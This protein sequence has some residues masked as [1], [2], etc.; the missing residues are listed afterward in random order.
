MFL[1]APVLTYDVNT[2]PFPLLASAE[3][4]NLNKA[5]FTA[6]ATNG[7][8]GDVVLEGIV[9]QLPVGSDASTLTLDP[10]VI[11]PVAPLGWTLASIQTPP[12]LVQF[13]FQPQAG[14]SVLPK[15]Q[16]LPFVFNNIEVNRTPGTF[17]VAITEGTG[18][19]VP[20]DCPVYTTH[21]TKFP[22]WLGAGIVLGESGEHSVSGQHHAV[23][24]WS[25]GRHLHHPIHGQWTSGERPRSGRSAAGK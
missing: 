10:S 18:N 9:V 21:I 25:A 1:T 22:Q 11:G 2:V 13:V 7:T 20:P 17:A 16:S 15:G 5:T 23:L 12:G 8:G 24:V 14:H 19:C 6:L 4:G 3:T